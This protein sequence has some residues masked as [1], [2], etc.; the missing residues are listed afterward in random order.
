MRR[1]LA[2]RRGLARRRPTGGRPV[3]RYGQHMVD[4][5]FFENARA[6]FMPN[7]VA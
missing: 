2:E 3:E 5:L 6:F 7:E 4:K 1:C